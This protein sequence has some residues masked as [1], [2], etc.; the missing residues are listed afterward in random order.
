IH[1]FFKFPP[2][3][4]SSKDYKLLPKKTI[5][6]IDLIFID[7]ISMVRADLLDHIDKLLRMSARDDRPFGGK[8]MLWTG[9]LFQLPPVLTG[10]QEKEYF[11]KIYESPYFFSSKVFKELQNF[12]LIELEEV[13][14]QKDR[15]FLNLL[16]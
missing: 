5:D 9:D 14:R 7:E 10:T 1:S 2:N 8:A 3:W 13:F 12:E 16:H 6:K 11:S 15:S 4:F